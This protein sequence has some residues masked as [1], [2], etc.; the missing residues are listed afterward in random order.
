MQKPKCRTRILQQVGRKLWI[1]PN[2]FGLGR[3]QR[4]GTAGRGAQPL[5]ELDQALDVLQELVPQLLVAGDQAGHPTVLTIFLLDRSSGTWGR[6][7]C[8]ARRLL[9]ALKRAIK[10]IPEIWRR[11]RLQ[12]AKSSR[13]SGIREIT[14]RKRI[15]LYS[16]SQGNRGQELLDDRR[17]G[18]ARTNKSKV[19][20]YH[21]AINECAFIPRW[22]TSCLLRWEASKGLLDPLAELEQE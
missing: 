2:R 17:K 6:W 1:V 10:D 8:H 7:R 9:R 4:L 14:A 11:V 5:P 20:L 21:T 3:Q 15:L 13:Q 16:Q 19:C 22:L 18:R 12:A